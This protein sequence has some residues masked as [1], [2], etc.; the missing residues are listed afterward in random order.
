MIWWDAVMIWS[1]RH[2]LHYAVQPS[3]VRQFAHLRRKVEADG[4]KSRAMHRHEQVPRPVRQF[5]HARPAQA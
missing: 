4:R 5:Q 3:S 2:A 1:G